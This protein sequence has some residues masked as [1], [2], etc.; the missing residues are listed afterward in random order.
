MKRIW[1]IKKKSGVSPVIATILMVAITVVLAAVLYVMVMN[2]SNN[3]GTTTPSG[4]FTVAQKTTNNTCINVFYG[5]FSSTTRQADVKISIENLSAST[6]TV[7]YYTFA[8]NTN[9]AIGTI[10]AGGPTPADSGVRQ[11]TYYDVAANNEINNGDYLQVY[12][13]MTG[14]AGIQYKISMI[15]TPTGSVINSLLYTF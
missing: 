13:T 5:Q 6:Q 9:G 14:S 7:A 3:P 4:S 2:M 11:I 15:Y 12:T 8:V 10:V 1:N